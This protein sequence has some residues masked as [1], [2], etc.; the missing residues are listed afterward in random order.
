VTLGVV[1][2]AAGR[3][4]RMGADVPKAFLRLA[5][6]PLVA[7]A[8]RP[9]LRF[10]GVVRIAVV[11]PDPAAAAG[12]QGFEDA[13]VVLVRGGAERQDSVASGIA[14]LGEVDLILVHDAARPLLEESTI[15]AV[16]EAAA[17]HGAAVPVLPVPDTVKEL[18]GAGFVAGTPSRDRLGLAQT[19]QGF[20][21]EL[22]RRAHARAAAAGERGTD[23]ASLVERLGEKV[24][25]VPGSP[26]NFKITT[27]DDL[28]RA[29]ILLSEES[30]G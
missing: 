6:L 9:F 3:G 12:I 25:A 17:R 24:A 23:E 28:R 20:R 4:T 7:H 15:R 13:R 22:L 8:I 10:S 27:A 18:D 19:P 1:V 14:A 2:A 26:R 29:E 30:R 16:V 5:G 21:S 11:L